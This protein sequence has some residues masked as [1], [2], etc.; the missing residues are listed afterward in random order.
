MNYTLLREELVRYEGLKY[1]VYLDTENLPTV[2]IGH[3]LLESEK[4]NFPVGTNVSYMQ[5]ENW[6]AK[7]VNTA[8]ETAIKVLGKEAFDS[9]DEV[10][11]RIV[12]NLAF[13]LGFNRLSGFKNTL[14]A[15]RRHDFNAASLGMQNSK[16]Y[17]Q[18]GR[19]GVEMV[20]A[21]RN[22]YYS[23]Q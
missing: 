16:W 18:V 20:D 11:Q 7:D 12:V 21:M 2:G 17:T 9:L 23:W 4:P 22:G 14:A 10:R 3:F 13:N 5:V 8:V 19:R 15:I 6:F 1:Q